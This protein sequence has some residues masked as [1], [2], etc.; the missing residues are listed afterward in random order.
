VAVE[1]REQYL[2]LTARGER[3][4]EVSGRFMFEANAPSDYPKVGDWAVVTDD[5]SWK[6]AIIHA[7]LPRRTRLSRNAAGTRTEEQVLAANIDVIVLVQGLDFDYNLRRLERELVMVK[8]SGAEGIVILN[9]TDLV[10]DPG[11]M[12]AKVREASPKTRVL[13]VSALT[14]DGLEDLRRCLHPRKT[15]IFL[16][17]SGV[18]KSTLINRLAGAEV[19]DTAPVREDDSKGR[20]TTSRRQLLLLSGGALL[21]DTPGV[22][23][24]RLWEAD[25]AVDDVFSDISALAAG[26]RYADCVHVKETGCAVRNAVAA[27]SLPAER[28]ESYLKLR[29]ELASLES[30]QREK[31]GSDKKEWSKDIHRAL[32]TFKKVNPKS[33]FRD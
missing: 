21:I 25:G 12:I 20:H 28:Y 13:A 27:G 22:R 30:R 19:L 16:G 1:N 4:A 6:T 11:A 2:L 3:P 23:E 18:G 31:P 33:R 29:K 17:S 24:F 32:K 7:L 10:P 9:K 15:Y 26:C 5:P 14:S 8:K